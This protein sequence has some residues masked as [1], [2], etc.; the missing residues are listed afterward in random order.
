MQG[1]P[2]HA[3]WQDSGCPVSPELPL[4][5]QHSLAA[6]P[7]IILEVNKFK[8]LNIQ[9]I[10]LNTMQRCTL[11]SKEVSTLSGSI[12]SILNSINNFCISPLSSFTFYIFDTDQNLL[13]LFLLLIFPS[14]F[15]PSN[16]YCKTFWLLT[17]M[18]KKTKLENLL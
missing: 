14:I 3:A 1:H 2:S 15:L 13:G 12:K 5:L 9:T 17:L 11:I 7:C 16:L 6:S 4:R 10:Q 18:P 8:M